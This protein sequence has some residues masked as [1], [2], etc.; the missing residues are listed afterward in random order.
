MKSKLTLSPAEFVRGMN[1]RSGARVVALS[2]A[3]AALLATGLTIG[4]RG[5][6]AQ[7]RGGQ[8]DYSTVDDFM[9]GGTHLLRND[10]LVMTFNYRSASNE[11]RGTLFTAGTTDSQGAFLNDRQ[12]IPQGTPGCATS[13]GCQYDYHQFVGNRPATGRFFNTPNDTM[14][15]YPVLLDG[16]PYFVSLAGKTV[17]TPAPGAGLTW[18]TAQSID[19]VTGGDSFLAGVGDFN[20]DGYDDLLM[21]W[22]N[23][24]VSPSTPK[25]SIATAVDVNDPSKG[26]KFGPVFATTDQDGIRELA[27]GDFNG[28]RQSDIAYL[29]VAQGAQLSLFTLTVDPATLAISAGG[30]V[31]L[32][33]L[34]SVAVNTALTMTPG[35]FTAAVNQQLAVGFQVGSGQNMK[36]QIVDFD[37][38]SIQP[39][40]ITTLDV[41]TAANNPVLKLKAGKLDWSN[42]YD[43]I[44]WMSSTIDNGTRLEV[45]TVDPANLTVTTKA[46]TV[47]SGDADTNAV[48]F[49]RDIA[50][51]NF[52]HMQQSAADPTQKE[53]DPNL[54]IAMIGLRVNK[55]NGEIGTMGVGIFDV[56]EDFS[57]ITTTSYTALDQTFLDNRGLTEASIVA[58]DLHGRS[59]RLGAG[60]KFTIENY[61]YPSVI[62][63]MPPMHID[64][65]IPSGETAPTVFNASAVPS[66]FWTKYDVQKDGNADTQVTDDQ[67]HSFGF[68]EQVSG[69]I[70]FGATPRRRR[71]SRS[72]IQ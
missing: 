11:T 31:P 27:V 26:F 9:N 8:P 2:L 30:S 59:Y 72:K 60:T 14:V 22:S 19:F 36:V 3:L 6:R 4:Q 16:Y 50:L 28:D 46:N 45:L 35:K 18:T 38:Q 58:G 42:P 44:V 40:L 53:R 21:A 66:G 17:T 70:Q 69:Y 67:S 20:N 54:Q 65:V 24:S 51:G 13:G 34:A 32:Y 57:T 61:S 63:A 23:T 1:Q 47:F 55:Q 10:D 62:T 49:G 68:Q 5:S 43:Q 37:P 48:V 41:P 33:T 12:I 64:Y 7:S 29:S 56:S 25:L 39:K 52:D 71:A 15:Q